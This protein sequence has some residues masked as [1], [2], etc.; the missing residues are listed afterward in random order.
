MTSVQDDA[1]T[2]V[3]VP[4]AQ[5]ENSSNEQNQNPNEETDSSEPHSLLSMSQKRRKMDKM[6]P[7]RFHA[8]C[9]DNVLLNRT[10]VTACRDESNNTS[11]YVFTERAIKNNEKV[12]IRIMEVVPPADGSLTV[13]VTTFDPATLPLSEMP[14]DLTKLVMKP[15]YWN[16]KLDAA[17]KLNNKSILAF[18]IDES[19]QIWCDNIDFSKPQMC[20][21]MDRKSEDVYMFFDMSGSTKLIR[22]LGVSKVR[23]KP[24]DGGTVRRNSSTNALA[25]RNRIETVEIRKSIQP[26]T[27]EKA[28]AKS[29]V[30]TANVMT[31]DLSLGNKTVPQVPDPKNMTVLTSTTKLAVI[32]TVG[33]LNNGCN[34][35]SC[36]IRKYYQR[37]EERGTL[38]KF[39]S[40][41]LEKSSNGSSPTST[42]VK[43]E[44]ANPLSQNLTMNQVTCTSGTFMTTTT[45]RQ[46]P[47][48]KQTMV[49]G[50]IG[51]SRKIRKYHEQ[52]GIR[53]ILDK[54][55]SAVIEEIAT[56]CSS[57]SNEAKTQMV[58]PVPVA[59]YMKNGTPAVENTVFQNLTAK[60][61]EE[62]LNT[63]MII[64]ENA[65]VV[66]NP[67]NGWIGVPRRMR[68]Y[69]KRT[70]IRG[71]LDK[72]YSTML[73]ETEPDAQI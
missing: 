26:S 7:L 34:V 59:S 19:D 14:E 42:V 66:R 31:T 30:E 8:V 65:R 46:S 54:F 39:Y 16:F 20:F 29:L 10:C 25:T 64:Q 51:M 32:K 61:V 55:Y 50:C 21:Q 48:A 73:E 58:E 23:I 3:S 62:T 43:S 47:P 13:G 2:P 45:S 35:M 70:D 27:S 52:I 56:E 15:G 17:N 5:V 1:Q 28:E 69:L 22:V 49:H 57:V 24:A 36:R 41:V 38:D 67:V 72:F 63:T 11:A 60:Q 18:W 53:G 6:T 68:K 71:T 37:A 9:G 40:A 12:W 33:S 4:T 44:S